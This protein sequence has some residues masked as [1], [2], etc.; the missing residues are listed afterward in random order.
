MTK[1]QEK[2]IEKIQKLVQS[3]LYED[4]EIK[5]WEINENKH[6]ASLIIEYGMI[7]DEGTMAAIIGRNR[8]Q[9]FIGKRGAVTY[10][11]NKNS[12]F[13]T[14]RFKG[15]SILQAVCDQR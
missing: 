1:A 3:E 14:K 5:T 9:L 12:R 4:C 2:A 6:F 10:P 13:Y 8:A 15:Y 11:V 7:N